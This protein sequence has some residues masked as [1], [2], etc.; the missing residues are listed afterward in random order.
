MGEA[1]ERVKVLMLIRAEA[2][3]HREMA[4]KM[5]INGNKPEARAWTRIAEALSRVANQ[6]E[7]G[8]HE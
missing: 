5:T 4:N 8:E 1:I 6:I 7:R 2:Q 3:R